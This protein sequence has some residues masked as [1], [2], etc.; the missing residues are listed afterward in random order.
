MKDISDKL[1]Y[2]GKEYPLVFNL[3]VLEEI[4]EEYGTI[5]KWIEAAYGKETGEPSAKA[6][7]FGIRAMVN[8]AIDMAEEE[9]EPAGELEKISLKQANRMLTELIKT[10]G[11]EKTIGT[12]DRLMSESMQSG[13][14][15]KNE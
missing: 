11:L 10:E 12:I 6:L 8:E 1:N 7:S 13:K 2:K 9:H 3:N 15:S 4:Q 5:T 14:D